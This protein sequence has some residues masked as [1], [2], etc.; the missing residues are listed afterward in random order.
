VEERRRGYVFEGKIA[1]DGFLASQAIFQHVVR[2]QRDSRSP[3]L[4]FVRPIRQP[5]AL[6][7]PCWQRSEKSMTVAGSGTSARTAGAR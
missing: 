7:G 4:G 3:P 5:E 6:A 1:L 2:P